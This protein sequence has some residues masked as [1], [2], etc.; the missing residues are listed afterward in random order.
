VWYS[1]RDSE[2]EARKASA[3]SLEVRE[4]PGVYVPEGLKLEARNVEAKNSR[5]GYRAAKRKVGKARG[6]QRQNQKA[7]KK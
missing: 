7:V 2:E 6:T 3:E 4:V 1:G 5:V